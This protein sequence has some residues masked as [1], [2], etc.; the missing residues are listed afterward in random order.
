MSAPAR[1]DPAELEKIPDSGPPFGDLRPR[2]DPVVARYP[3]RA[4]AMLPVLWVVQRA[5][6]GWLSP[7]RG[8]PTLGRRG[9]STV[10]TCAGCSTASV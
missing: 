8:S 2:L 9:G 10:A 7:P 6:D 5:R 3:V 4:G 1:I